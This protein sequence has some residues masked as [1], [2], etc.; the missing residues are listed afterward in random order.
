[1]LKLILVMLNLTSIALAFVLL[2]Q[3]FATNGSISVTSSRSHNVL[4]LTLLLVVFTGAA[5]ISTFIMMIVEQR[6]AWMIF[7]WLLPT[8]F[9]SLAYCLFVLGRPKVCRVCGGRGGFF[10]ACPNCG[11]YFPQRLSCATCRGGGVV[12]TGQ[13]CSQCGGTGRIAVRGK[14][15][16]PVY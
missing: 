6:W 2:V 14:A 3:F 13:R 15:L 16:R 12:P 1:M 9:T 11:G 8:P 10:V 4:V 5:L 7:L